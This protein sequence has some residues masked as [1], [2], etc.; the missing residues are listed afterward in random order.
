MPQRELSKERHELAQEIEDAAAKLGLLLSE[1]ESLHRRHAATLREAGRPLDYGFS[2][3]EIVTGWWR[4]R[5]GGFNSLTG[6]SAPFHA[7]QDAPLHERDP[8]ALL[9]WE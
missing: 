8:L 9:E 5:F 7:S 1:Y 6:T 2:L 3:S 4:H